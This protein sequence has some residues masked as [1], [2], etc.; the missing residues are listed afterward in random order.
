[1]H[2]IEVLR[3][4]FLNNGSFSA[5]SETRYAY[6]YAVTAAVFLALASWQLLWPL[7]LNWGAADIWQHLAALNAVIENPRHPNNPFVDTTDPTRL[8]GPYWVITGTLARLLGGSALQALVAAGIFS[9]A[10]WLGALFLFGRAWLGSSRGALVLLL[11]VV[12]GWAWPPSFTGYHSPLAIVTGAAYPAFLLLGLTLIL[13]T[14]SIRMLEVGGGLFTILLLTAFMVA[15]HPF[16]AAVGIAGA[17]AFGLVAGEVPTL[18][19]MRLLAGIALGALL[20]LFWPYYSVM[21]VLRSADNP[22]WTT[23]A[24][25]YSPRWLAQSLVPAIFGLAG[26]LNRRSLPL[27]ILLALCTAGFLLG[28]TEQFAAG[29]R[30]LPYIT[31]ILQI[32]L[33]QLLLTGWES[34][35]LR[36][37]VLGL[38]AIL[39]LVQLQW[40]IGIAGA[41][42]SDIRQNGN[43]LS[44][45]K[46][47]T[48]GL[49]RC[50]GIAGFETA[51]FPIV[52][53]GRRMMST[54]FAEPLVAD[55]AKR[56]ADTR[57]LFDPAK[58]AAVRQ[59]LAA[60]RNV[61]FLVVDDRATPPAILRMLQAEADGWRRAGYLILFRVPNVDKRTASDAANYQE[62]CR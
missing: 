29:H 49:P 13:W 15:T 52:A 17:V 32:G 61:H 35:R 25:F 20:A 8:F 58:P 18:W 24:N 21:S 38:A 5:S 37:P 60:R 54:P 12:L 40:T 11:A 36:L 16:G 27:T 4:I 56:Q 6:Y 30:L 19:R 23:S 47:L 59:A 41:M 26:L 57:A 9:V 10:L 51:S 7:R 3:L 48:R 31:L 43:L 33:A 46:A 50:T 45:A 14:L 42:R 55:M 28:T 53:T 62:N 44:A 39:A 34:H 22:A 1:M 2:R